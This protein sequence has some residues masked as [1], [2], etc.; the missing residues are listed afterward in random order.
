[1]RE[2]LAASELIVFSD[3]VGAPFTEEE[4][5][6]LL[7]M[8]QQAQDAFCEQY[9]SAGINNGWYVYKGDSFHSSAYWARRFTWEFGNLTAS[10]FE[11]FLRK[12]DG[13]TFKARHAV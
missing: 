11:E 13:D 5:K 8:M 9:S 6:A 3:D 10:T 4:K 12:L 7:N 1:M 2:P